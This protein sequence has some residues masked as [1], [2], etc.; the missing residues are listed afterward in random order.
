MTVVLNPKE[1]FI[2]EVGPV[3]A[4]TQQLCRI[5]RSFAI[6]SKP[7]TV[8]QYLRCRK[9]HQYHKVFTPTEDCPANLL[10][11]F[12]AAAYCNWLSE[13]EGLPK[14]QWCYVPN[15]KG[16]YAAGMTMAPGYLKRTGYRLPRVAEWEYACRAGSVTKWS[17][18]DSGDLLGGYGWFHLNSQEKNHPVGLLRPNDQGMFDMHGNGWNWCQDVHRTV[19]PPLPTAFIDDDDVMA[20]D[21]RANRVSCGGTFSG[22]ALS[23]RS[24]SRWG[25]SPSHRYNNHYGLRVA[26]TVAP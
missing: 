2:G 1:F 21:P 12:D 24:V 26:R 13:Q 25:A 7:V 16:E 10:S 3:I 17:F 19:G 15:E 20:I 4:A 23:N 14:E 22:L 18:G 8:G 6:A 9:D 11:W 5:D